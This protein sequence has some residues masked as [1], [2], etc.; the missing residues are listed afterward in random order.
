MAD[1]KRGIKNDKPQNEKPA[2][3]PKDTAAKPEPQT[4]EKTEPKP[5]SGPANDPKFHKSYT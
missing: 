5:G 2:N 1:T 3:E 4:Q